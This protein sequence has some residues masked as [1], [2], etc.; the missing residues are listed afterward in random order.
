MINLDYILKI[1]SI[2]TEK[3]FN[4]NKMEIR[5]SIPK[6]E[7]NVLNYELFNKYR[8]NFVMNPDIIDINISGIKFLITKG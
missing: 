5:Y 8:G 6:D 4:S 3:G 7:F 2:L 1:S